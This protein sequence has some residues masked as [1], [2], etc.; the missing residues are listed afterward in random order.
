MVE[1]ANCEK[2]AGEG[3]PQMPPPAEGTLDRLISGVPLADAPDW[4]LNQSQTK[5]TASARE[6]DPD[7]KIPAGQ[8]N[9]TLFK[10]AVRCFKNGLS[11]SALL[12]AIKELNRT[13]CEPPLLEAEV[14]KIVN[15]AANYTPVSHDGSSAQLIST[16][17]P[18]PDPLAAEAFHGLAG[19]F[20]RI[21]ESHTESD[22]AALLIQFLASFGNVI[23]R[24]PHWKVGGTS[25]HLNL[26]GNLVGSTSRARKGT[27]L[28]LVLDFFNRADPGWGEKC[29]RSGL[30]S[31]EGLLSILRDPDVKDSESADP[32]ASEKRLLLIESEF[33]KVLEVMKRQGNTLSHIIR[34]AWDSGTIRTLTK[35]NA[36]TVTGAHISIVGH[37]TRE[38]LHK[39]LSASD[40]SNGFANRFLWFAVQRSKFLPRGGNLDP[41]S[42]NQLVTRLINAI[43]AACQVG[44]MGMT[45]A[46]WQ[47]WEAGIYQEL[48]RDIPGLFGKVT[49]RAEAQVRRLACIYALLDQSSIVDLP[50][51]AAAL[52]VWQYAEDS[53]RFI[54]G[55]RIGDGLADKILAALREVPG[56]LS[57]SEIYNEVCKKNKS[58]SEIEAALSL[59][60]QKGMVA[61]RIDSY[62]KRPTETWTYVRP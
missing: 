59:L 16:P 62:A 41:A 13:Q 23:G 15:S 54:F 45:E 18:W 51:L 27:S 8:R 48:S 53:A 58:R 26:F 3:N 1:I 28:D 49:A 24:G 14:E 52:A 56:G 39:M 7:G 9:D 12:A 36:I 20:V 37:I 33:G 5:K 40:S 29:R 21:V 43:A 17:I 55:D 4:V 44:E 11:A 46:A 32:G 19:D 47:V 10:Q 61:K 31:G 25:H 22:P 30:S 42:L 2:P 34:Q 38:E 60:Q 6:T 35:N 57:R 50:H